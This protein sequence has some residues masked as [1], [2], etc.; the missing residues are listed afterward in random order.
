M[1]FFFSQISECWCISYWN[2]GMEFF[3]FKPLQGETV[4]P[5]KIS[6]VPTASKWG[7]L[8]LQGFQTACAVHPNFLWCGNRCSMILPTGPLGKYPK[9]PLS[10]PQRKEFSRHKRS[11]KHPG[12]H[13]PGSPM[14]GI[15]WDLRGVVGCLTWPIA[16]SQMSLVY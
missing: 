11:V 14:G 10:A 5:Q 8:L 7:N 3:W 12:A 15:W 9:L 1:H 4:F 13:L 16:M 2:L 6:L